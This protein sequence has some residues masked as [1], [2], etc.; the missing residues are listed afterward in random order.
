MKRAQINW[1]SEDWILFYRAAPSRF[2][3]RPQLLTRT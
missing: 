3:V 1:R 2:L